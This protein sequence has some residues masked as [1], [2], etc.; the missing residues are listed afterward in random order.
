MTNIVGRTALALLL[1]AS[2][3]AAHAANDR[4]RIM[5]GGIEKQIYLPAILAQLLGYFKEQ[6]LDVELLTEPSGVHAEDELLAGSVHGVVGFYDHTIDLQAKGK[7]VQSVV[8][9]AQAPGEAELVATRHAGEI[10]TPADFKGRSLGVTGLGSSTHFLTNYLAI[11]NGVKP[12]EIKL[13]AV[14]SGATFVAAMRQHVIDAGMTTEPTISQLLKSGES[15]IMVDLRTPQ[16]TQKVLGGLYPA[17]CLYMTSVWIN[18]HKPQVQKLANAL[19]KTLKYIDTHTPEQIAA[20][21]PSEYHVGERAMYVEAL[22]ASKSMFTVDGRMPASG[23]E[24]VLKVLKVANRLVKGKT[25]DLSKT[26]ATEFVDAA[27]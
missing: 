16:S 14:G 11:V 4:I 26:F 17:A 18:T 3:M 21:L 1:A 12:G 25:I 5:V 27:R 15:K 24:T 7:F 20:E 19:V 13:R 10:N 6:G 22:R 9:F 23:P 8:Q 2:A